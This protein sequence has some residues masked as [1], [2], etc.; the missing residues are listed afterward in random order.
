MANVGG[1][2]RRVQ[3]LAD[4]VGEGLG[5]EVV[6]VSFV[7][8]GPHRVLRVT[9]DHPNGIGIDDCER[10]SNAFG[11]VLDEE[12]PIS[13]SYLLEVSSPGIDR[14]LTK[15]E[16]FSR[17]AGQEAELRLYS[18]VQGRKKFRGTLVGWSPE[19]EG[20]VLMKCDGEE[21]A[22]PWSNIS[23]ARLYEG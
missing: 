9:I 6:E 20:Q 4:R 7:K 22:I 18:P 1:T 5:Y 2:R 16:H 21:L 3:E 23:R 15:P 11:Q 17:F 10:F 13:T 19:A 8:E 14:P 12:D